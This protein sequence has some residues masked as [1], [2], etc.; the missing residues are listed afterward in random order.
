MADKHFRITTALFIFANFKFGDVTS[1]IIVQSNGNFTLQPNVQSPPEDILWRWNE[2]KVVEFYQKEMVDY[3]QFKGRTT[4]DLTTGALT[5]THLTEADSGEYVGE[6]QIKGELVHHRQTVKVFD[7]VGKPAVT[8]Q[9]NGSS[10]T[11]LCSGGDRPSTQYRWE[12]PAIEPQPGSQLKIEAAESSDAIYTCVLHNPV[13]KPAVTC[14]VNGP[15]VTL[16][17][18][19]GDR[20]STQYRWEGPAIEPQPGSQ[21]KIEAAESSDAVYTCVLHNPVGESR[22]DFPVKSCFPAPGKAH[23]ADVGTEHRPAILAATVHP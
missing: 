17:C 16:L 22:T 5:L 10:V 23:S 11:L 8:C 1:E 18:S 19:G 4:L 7:A 21:L 3:G 9:V 2:N 15:S 20:P 12:G 14:Q 13:G 6:L